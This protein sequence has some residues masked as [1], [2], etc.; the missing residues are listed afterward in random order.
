[1][2]VGREDSESEGC[3]FVLRLESSGS[4]EAA[5]AK[6]LDSSEVSSCVI[7][8]DNLQIRFVS[9][10]KV[11]DELI[12]KIYLRGGLVWSTRHALSADPPPS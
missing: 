3:I 2:A 11:A 6:L 8:P 10:P 12:Q 5:F 9:F 7:E 1:M 4:L